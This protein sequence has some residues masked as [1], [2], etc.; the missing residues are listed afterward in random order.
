MG[1]CSLTA[2]VG[3]VQYSWL[4]AVFIHRIDLGTFPMQIA[5]FKI[6]QTADDEVILEC[7]VQWGSNANAKASARVTFGG[8]TVELPVQVF[9]IMVGLY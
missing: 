9:N 6:Y 2:R 5:G 4:T 3:L 7:A 8:I 1:C